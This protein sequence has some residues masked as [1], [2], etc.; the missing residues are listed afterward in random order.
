MKKHLVAKLIL[1]MGICLMFWQKAFS[2]AP[3]ISYTNTQTIVAG[4][5]ITPI[6]PT[7]SGGA[8][9]VNG[10]TSLLAGT[11]GSRGSSDGSTGTSFSN[12]IGM[13]V[14]ANGN[15]YVADEGNYKIRKITPAGV[16]STFAGTGSPG[17][18]NNS[19]PT[20]ASFNSPFG[21]CFDMVGNMYVADYFNN[22][23]RKITPAGVVSTLAGNGT[24]G[25]VN[26]APGSAE[27]NSPTGVAADALGNVYVADFGNHMIRK[28]TPDGTVSLFAG[29]N[30]YGYADGQGALAKFGGPQTLGFD[31]QG[32]L[33]VA[34]KS[35]NMIRK[36]TPNGTV[37][38]LAGQTTAGY[39]NG[40]GSAAQFNNPAGLAIDASG[41]IYVPDYNNNR[42]RIVS[43][44]GVVS[45]LSGTGIV[46]SANGAG[47]SATFNNPYGIAI[48]KSGNLYV[49]EFTN[50]TI[51]KVLSTPYTISPALPAGLNFNTA[52]GV[53]SGAAI[54]SSPSTTYTIT[55][56]NLSGS[57]TTTLT[58]AVNAASIAPSQN[59][60]YI[61]TYVPRVSGLTSATAV[62]N[63]SPDKT[64]I[65]TEIKYFDGLGRPI[66]TVK[67]KGSPNGRDL[68][69]PV[70][71]DSQGREAYKY[72][73]YAVTG[74]S[75][76]DGSYKTDALTAAAGVSYFYNPTGSGISGNQQSN[77]IV[78]NPNPYSQI[79]FEA[80][81]LNRV[82]EQGAPGT[83]WQ[84][85]ANSNTGHTVKT[86][87]TTNNTTAI[88]DTANTTLVALYT[89]TV[90]SDQSRTLTRASGTAGNYDAGQLYLT[91]TYNENWTGGRS[92]TSEEYKDIEGHVVLKR[93]FN[94]VR[95]THVT[96]IMSTYYVY[97]DLGNLAFVLTPMSGA[98]GA[99]PSQALLDN[100]CYQYRYDEQNR[101]TQKKLPGKGWEYTVY[102]KLDQPVLTQDSVQRANNQ[103][104]VTKYDAL[105]RV[106]MT[107]LFNSSATQNTQKTNI[108]AYSQWDIRDYTNTSTGYLMNSY[109]GP[110][111]ILTINYYDDYNYGNVA[112]APTNYAAPSGSST[113]TRGLLTGKQTAVLNTPTDMLWDVP[114]YDDL[115][116]TI[117][118]YTEHYLGGTAN[119]NNYDA[120]TTTYNF[121]NAPTT[122]TRQHYTSSS[123]TI[124]MLTATNTYMYDHMGR[125]LKT[126]E[127]LTYGSN[128]PTGNTLVSQVD[129]NE[130]GQVLAKRLHSTDSLNFYQNIAYTYNERGWLLTSSAP[131]FAMNLYYNTSAGI[132]AWNGDIKYQYWGT[133]STVMN[134]HF[135]YDM[136]AQDRLLA[137]S[138]TINYDEYPIYD[139]NGNI[140]AL[141]RGV[142]PTTYTNTDQLLY[143]Y[144]DVNGNYTN[145][146]QSV[147]DLNANTYT[148]GLPGGVTKYTYD[149]N[150]NLLTQRNQ[151]SNTQQ[152]K[153][154]TYNLLNLP[155]II[156]ANT[157]LTTSTTLTYIYDAAGNKLRRTSTGLSDVTDYISG[158][159]YDAYN[160]AQSNLNF[161]QT[162][163]GKA[164]YLQSTGGFDYYY[165][166]GDNLGNTRVTFDTKL[167]SASLYQTDD[168]FPFGLEIPEGTI[169]NPKNEYLYNKKELQEELGQYDYGA[170][171]YDPVIG[172]WGVVDPMAENSRRFSPYTYVENNPI[173]NLD[174]D[175]MEV[176]LGQG[177]AG[178]D[179][180][181]EEDAQNLFRDLQQQQQEQGGPGDKKKKQE[182]KKKK[183]EENKSSGANPRHAP[184]W[185][186]KV[187]IISWSAET[188]DNVENGNYWTAAG[189]E[190]DG[191]A[192][193]LF[194]GEMFLEKGITTGLA[195]LFTRDA[196]SAVTIEFGG[197]AKASWHAVRHLI[198]EAGM[199]EAEV[200]AVKD[201]ITKDVSKV[202]GSIK[203]GAKVLTRPIIVNGVKLEYNVFR[204]TNG[205][206]NVGRIV[207]AKP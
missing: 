12:P 11:V 65:Q 191:M 118:T 56:Y 46:G 86:I 143:N 108:Y 102:N 194:T 72:L 25:Y 14:D 41:T 83:P 32:N 140:T 114:Y 7:N 90:N 117:K 201:A 97:D 129:Y 180:Y 174:P 44:S 178:G 172:R 26:G 96:E 151:N 51:R 81:P 195:S 73:P 74:S 77:G 38:T 70:A 53:I 131:L 198:D 200:Q 39:T 36:I 202:A 106:I 152:D 128:L 153:T 75:N 144:L 124:P 95:T 61:M 37:S 91:I 155:K 1:C 135:A 50:L 13:A 207:L 185:E 35:N 122:V 157:G 171:F 31:P 149:G 28:I 133:P 71:Y 58:F 125:K 109:P 30:V 2:Q 136:D 205:V 158:I 62:V 113:M 49:S 93:T 120:I 52:T 15:I 160:G 121:T 111:T 141:N 206:L 94:Y 165:Y 148:T 137:G 156:T 105:G 189:R 159:Q 8:V 126:W 68:V 132:K 9:A 168:Y 21:I 57:S 181:T 142:G 123:T 100:L 27:F 182:E 20:Q 203:T 147:N 103:W 76:S 19:V 66:Q 82:I 196:A 85:V 48:D 33:I 84:P 3:N 79:V 110:S 78:V 6:S 24:A 89:A 138:S 163:E 107:G 34:D 167:S 116:R 69:Q 139:M 45:N 119:T 146:L 67:V 204:R 183:P 55:A 99:Q 130:L 127:Q 59:M 104:S 101:L 175:G 193:A 145:Q 115:G 190:A 169:P 22:M 23:I 173:R 63:A 10:Q 188:W 161:I 60:N 5:A 197:G 184:A 92:G 87:Y 17:S 80:S 164:A 199:N 42:I 88:T 112:G 98:D 166:L 179:L 43:Q 162:E 186:Y 4:T 29:Q 170:R 187:P 16:V 134:Q 54:S 64:K 177:I 47:S 150:G 18:T 154:Y 176:F 40:N 192:T